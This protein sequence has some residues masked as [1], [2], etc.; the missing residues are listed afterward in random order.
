MPER[1][2]SSITFTVEESIWFERGQEVDEL[3]SIS[4]SP[5]IELLNEED[6]VVLKGTLEL[7]GE[8]KHVN[9]E[10]EVAFPIMGRQY[11]QSV[12]IRNETESEFFH[13]LPLDITIPKRKVK[14]LED[15]A[16]DIESF[17][18]HLSENCRLQ[19]LADIEIRGVYEEEESIL[20]TVEE[21]ADDLLDHYEESPSRVEPATPINNE[22][23]V[24]EEI[25]RKTTELQEEELEEILLEVQPGEHEVEAKVRE[26]ELQG[27][28]DEQQEI[29]VETREGEQ[30]EIQV[31]TREGE[32]R[33]TQVDTRENDQQEIQ[34]EAVE[35]EERNTKVEAQEEQHE[36]ELETLHEEHDI[37]VEVRQEEQGHHQVEE[38]REKQ[39]D[40]LVEILE[41]ENDEDFYDLFKIEANIIPEKRELTDVRP[42]LDYHLPK[43]PEILIESLERRGR[44]HMPIESSSP[45]IES[46]SHMSNVKYDEVESSS[47]LQEE[48]NKEKKKKDKYKSMSFADFFARKDEGASAKLKVCLVQHG[49]SIQGLAD[50]YKVTVQQILRANQLEANHEVYEG[51]VLYIPVKV[52]SLKSI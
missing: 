37:H 43:L 14:K 36:I 38:A 35:K 47:H 44:D 40:P 52:S 24:I 12:E 10:N 31:E 11:I 41:K 39:Q 45:Y 22:S 2:E 13:Q 51:Q 48:K 5:H 46:S 25:D 26:A 19:L 7:S 28:G 21:D 1:K 15:I 17:D 9:E 4:L 49:D 8:Y 42:T 50:K 20:D 3:I 27:Q 18:Y 6:Y 16:V 30:Q 29:Q 33:E 34:M 32:Q 23:S